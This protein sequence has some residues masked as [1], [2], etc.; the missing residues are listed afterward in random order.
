MQSFRVFKRALPYQ[1]NILPKNYHTVRLTENT[2]SLNTESRVHHVWHVV[3]Y[4]NEAN[5]CV[6]KIIWLLKI[7]IET[8][9]IIN[10]IFELKMSR[11][12]I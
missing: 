3:L 7:E 11:K 2:C 10:S 5:K 4:I 6:K 9:I 12:I 1:T 8:K